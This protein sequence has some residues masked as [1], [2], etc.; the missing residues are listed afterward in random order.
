M[1][2]FIKKKLFYY[3]ITAVTLLLIYN[4]SGLKTSNSNNQN[5]VAKNKLTGIEI[6]F[7]DV[8]QADSALIT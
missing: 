2:K 1:K 7:I 6:E 4:Y 8:G 3:V 5:N